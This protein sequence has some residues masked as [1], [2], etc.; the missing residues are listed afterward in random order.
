MW[1]QASLGSIPSTFTLKVL[2]VIC[3]VVSG[4]K[5]PAAQD[6]PRQSMPHWTDHTGGANATNAGRC[7]HS[8]EEP[9][10]MQYCDHLT[11]THGKKQHKTP[12]L[13]DV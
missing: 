10:L 3:C 9:T 11:F 6:T 8:V 7:P 4:F 2:L 1:M 12:L 13:C 5:T